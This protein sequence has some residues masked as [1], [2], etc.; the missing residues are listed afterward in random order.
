LNTHTHIDVGACPQGYPEADQGQGN[1][2]LG[3][4][5]SQIQALFSLPSSR[6]YTNLGNHFVDGFVVMINRVILCWIP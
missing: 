1:K 5:T 6:I 4:L 2:E 3:A